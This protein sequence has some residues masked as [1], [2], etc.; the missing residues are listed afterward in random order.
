MNKIRY[1]PSITVEVPIVILTTAGVICDNFI[2]G[3]FLFMTLNVLFA[4]TLYWNL[5]LC[6][7]NNLSF[8]RILLLSVGSLLLFLSFYLEKYFGIW[9]TYSFWCAYFIINFFII[10][11]TS[12]CSFLLTFS[13]Q[14]CI[15][16]IY[17]SVD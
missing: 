12:L 2:V 14:V 9:I 16:L 15:F 7:N 17:F 1:L 8:V 5:K 10:K 4:P 3:F 6:K 11:N 13:L